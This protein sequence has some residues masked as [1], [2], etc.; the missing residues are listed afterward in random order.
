MRTEL[1]AAVREWNG[2]EVEA[3]FE[4]WTAMESDTGFT[5]LG[6]RYSSRVSVPP[7]RIRA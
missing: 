1:R 6:L 5:L 4:V 7:G 2:G 3:A